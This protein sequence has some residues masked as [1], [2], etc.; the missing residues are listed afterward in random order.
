[1]N[2]TKQTFVQTMLLTLATSLTCLLAQTASA[3]TWNT[4]YRAANGNMVNAR[5]ELYGDRGHYDA[6][7]CRGTLSNVR[8]NY[9]PA[10]RTIS[11]SWR[12]CDGSTGS[13]SWNVNGT[14]FNGHWNFNGG[15]AAFPWNG[16][17][18][19]GGGNGGGG[20]FPPG[21]GGGGNGGGFPPGNGGGGFPPGNGGGGFPPGNGGGPD[22][23]DLLGGNGGGSTWQS[24]NGSQ[25][26][27][28]NGNATISDPNSGA[29]FSGNYYTNGSQGNVR[30][31]VG[32]RLQQF[33]IQRINANTIRIG[34]RIYR[35]R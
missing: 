4:T 22:L 32:N 27:F 28:D 25:C 29:V 33:R 8:S 5:V 20:G 15:G 10:G 17:L 19:G 18:A 6:P 26:S 30:F 34:S 31:T 23:N 2:L 35:R 21:N 24:D 7:G 12:F 16:Q 3:E 1:M 14:T 13:F 11:G 9:G